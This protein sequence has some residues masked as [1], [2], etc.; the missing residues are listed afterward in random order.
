MLVSI[1]IVDD[2]PQILRAL[3]RSLRDEGYTLSFSQD[4]LDALAQLAER[5]F[6][7]VVS[8]FAMPHM[9]GVELLAQ[10][11]ERRPSTLRMLMTGHADR[12]ATIRAINE[13]AICHYFEKPWVDTELKE[14]L[15]AAVRSVAT[16]RATKASAPD[17]AAATRRFGRGAYRRTA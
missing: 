8:D 11:R 7:I 1:L 17:L 2:E 4:P 6:D 13:G 12:Q 5:P 15:H 10:V 16:E 3:D 14:V 9:T